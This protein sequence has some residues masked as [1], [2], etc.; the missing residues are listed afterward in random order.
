[1]KRLMI[2]AMLA[3]LALSGCCRTGNSG[4]ES[5]ALSPASS[6]QVESGV[7]AFMQT[8]AH[9]VTQDGPSAW[10]R[11]FADDPAFFMA[12]NGSMAFGD[13][14]AAT[15]GIQGAA[16][17]IP[18]IELVWGSDLRI[19][20]LTPELAVVATSWREVQVNAAGKRVNESGFFTGVAEQRNGRWQLRDAHWSEAVPQEAAK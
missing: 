1:M 11:H 18:H 20:P 2:V 7:R 19:D 17:A 15:K 3:A 9:D 4:G 5:N 8:V 14:A 10:R 13:S 12:V 16:Q 6:A